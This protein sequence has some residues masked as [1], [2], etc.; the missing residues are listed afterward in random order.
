MAAPVRGL[1]CALK[2]SIVPPLVVILG[3]TGTGKSKL[4]IEIG[5]RR[6]GEII[7]ADSMQVRGHKRR[8]CGI[9]CGRIHI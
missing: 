4:A 1:Q 7:S 6:Q 5:K 2:K 8:G 9:L 3:A